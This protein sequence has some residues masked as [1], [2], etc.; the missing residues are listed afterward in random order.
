MED[1]EEENTVFTIKS[2]ASSAQYVTTED[3]F[4]VQNVLT[5][6]YLTLS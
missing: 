2:L 5:E 4:L 3:L 1:R 6:T